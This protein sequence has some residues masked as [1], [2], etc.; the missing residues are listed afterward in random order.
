MTANIAVREL[1]DRD[2]QPFYWIDYFM[3]I[4][5]YDAFLTVFIN[6]IISILCGKRSN[7]DAWRSW[8]SRWLIE[9]GYDSCGLYGL[10]LGKY[11]YK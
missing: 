1:Y 4:K 7:G 8:T 2:Y 5:F 9:N 11:N 3:D 10:S 6:N